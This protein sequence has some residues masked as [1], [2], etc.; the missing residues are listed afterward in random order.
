METKS[1][2]LQV[3]AVRAVGVWAQEV[4]EEERCSLSLSLIGELQLRR[5]ISDLGE[6]KGRLWHDTLSSFS[7]FFKIARHENVV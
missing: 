2:D 7:A 6:A 5:A 3:E 1:G 4:A